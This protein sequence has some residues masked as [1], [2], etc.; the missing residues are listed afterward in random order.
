MTDSRSPSSTGALDTETAPYR[1]CDI[2][3]RRRRKCNLD[4]PSCSFCIRNGMQCTYSS[5]KQKPGPRKG[6]VSTTTATL[7]S[8]LQ[9]L[10]SVLKSQQEQLDQR[11]PAPG[12]IEK[13]YENNNNNICSFRAD[14]LDNESYIPAL[15]STL[16]QWHNSTTLLGGITNNDVTCGA[17]A[18]PLEIYTKRNHLHQTGLQ[19]YLLSLYFDYLQP[20]VP[21]FRARP[22]YEDYHNGKITKELLAPMF[23]LAAPFSSD[24]SISVLSRLDFWQ[25]MML[26]HGSSGS[27]RTAALAEVRVAVLR[28]L[29]GYA[30][31]QGRQAWQQI[32]NL[33]RLACAYGLHKVDSPSNKTLMSEEDREERRYIWWSVS[34][35]DTH[36]NCIASTP[37]SIDPENVYTFL[38]STPVEE[39]TAGSTSPSVR[40]ILNTGSGRAEQVVQAIRSSGTNGGQ[41][42]YVM[43]EYMLREVSTIRRRLVLNPNS[44]I[45]DRLFAFRNLCSHI[46]LGMSTSYL[47][48][49]RNLV[50]NEAPFAHCKRLELLLHFHI[51]QITAHI[52]TLDHESHSFYDQLSQKAAMKD[53]QICI[54]ECEDI[55]GVFQHWEPSY[56]PRT[57]PTVCS[58]IWATCYLLALQTMHVATSADKK[59]QLENNLD[60]LSAS[61]E[62]FSKYW[63]IARA[64]L[65]ESTHPHSHPAGPTKWPFMYDAAGTVVPVDPDSENPTEFNLDSILVQDL[66]SYDVIDEDSLAI[67]PNTGQIMDSAAAVYNML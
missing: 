58:I 40:A 34:K 65:R 25:D 4:R 64:Q 42:I 38:V 32:G 6:R 36:S 33:T 24:P 22:F 39:F 16:D 30:H 2:C 49:S 43:F 1:V 35:L 29:Y 62:H 5:R 57:E 13:N 55:V 60:L 3:Q 48:P 63:P 20:I 53:W 19:L 28:A 14:L 10:E 15:E 11:T 31:F 26:D 18:L 51:V 8:K 59:V 27:P 46:R 50:L 61:L 9:N 37:F 12:T 66:K 67:A 23:A 52:P 7:I 17:S 56:Y 21:L 54:A 47:H 44:H 41:N 45:Q